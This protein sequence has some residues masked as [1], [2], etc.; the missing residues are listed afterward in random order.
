MSG[1]PYSWG[2]VGRRQLLRWEAAEG[3]MSVRSGAL[4]STCVCPHSAQSVQ[5]GGGK[6]GGGMVLEA[7]S[8]PA[9]DLARQMPGSGPG[10]R[11]GGLWASAMPLFTHEGL[12]T[13][14]GPERGILLGPG[15][16]AGAGNL[17]AAGSLW[18]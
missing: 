6:W 13:C 11:P 5:A 14:T 1:A 18:G 16:H 12:L 4:L 3:G 8:E 15:V 9:G 2:G 7:L 10:T 17:Q